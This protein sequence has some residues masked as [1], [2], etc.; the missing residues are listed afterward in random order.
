MAGDCIL[1]K[2]LR[3]STTRGRTGMLTV[4]FRARAKNHCRNGVNARKGKSKRYD[5]E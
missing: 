5:C 3:W 2:E 4:I 1:G